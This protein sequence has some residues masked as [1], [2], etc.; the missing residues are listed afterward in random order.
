MELYSRLNAP[1]GLKYP[2][3][4]LPT[5]DITS[6]RIPP[7]LSSLRSSY[8]FEDLRTLQG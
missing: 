6:I 8:R 4:L 5:L 7:I 3:P 1:E 2:P